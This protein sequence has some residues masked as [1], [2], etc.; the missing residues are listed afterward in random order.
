[1]LGGGASSGGWGQDWGPEAGNS[2]GTAP[3]LGAPAPEARTVDPP[4]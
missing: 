4:Q 1:M 3:G 2:Q